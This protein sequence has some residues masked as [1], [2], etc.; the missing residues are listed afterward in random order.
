M[1]ADFTR[2]KAEDV[3]AE[4]PA[5]D[6]AAAGQL[7]GWGH[8]ANEARDARRLQEAKAKAERWAWLLRLCRR[9]Q[10][11]HGVANMGHGSHDADCSMQSTVFIACR[12]F[13]RSIRSKA[14]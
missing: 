2:E 9:L 3:N 11:R 14:A 12:C 4:L 13:A 1:E 8:W 10:R 5:G 6:D 7:P